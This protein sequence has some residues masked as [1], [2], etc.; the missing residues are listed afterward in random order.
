MPKFSLCSD[1]HLNYSNLVLPG[2]DVLILAGDIME[3]GHLRR[4]DHRNKW[5]ITFNLNGQ[6]TIPRLSL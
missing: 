3:A 1:L 5:D 6:K 4:A 2:G